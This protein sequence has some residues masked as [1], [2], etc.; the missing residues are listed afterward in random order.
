M[1]TGPTSR[2][3]S[4]SPAAAG[5]TGVSFH[6]K[7]AT[8]KVSLL[9]AG[10]LTPPHGAGKSLQE[11]MQVTPCIPEQARDSSATVLGL[12]RKELSMALQLLFAGHLL[13][14]GS[15]ALL[16]V[17]GLGAP[18]CLACHRH[19]FRLRNCR[20]CRSH[21]ACSLRSSD[22]LL[23]QCQVAAISHLCLLDCE[24]LLVPAFSPLQNLMLL[25]TSLKLW[26]TLTM[27]THP[28]SVFHLRGGCFVSLR[29]L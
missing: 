17:G 12:G 19:S 7:E 15:Q 13:S 26:G 3:G 10:K 29:N 22:S 16:F 23:L 24:E 21:T 6:H 5:D 18:R 11:D 14:G 20:L 1:N 27:H 8:W 4:L 2:L 28:K 25:S 9:G